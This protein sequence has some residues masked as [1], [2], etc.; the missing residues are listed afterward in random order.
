MELEFGNYNYYKVIDELHE[1]KDKSDLCYIRRYRKPSIWYY[2]IPCAFDI[3]TTSYKFDN[4]RKGAWMYE[5]TF[6]IGDDLIIYGRNWVDWQVLTDLL[7]EIF[8][9]GEFKRLFIGIHNLSFEFQ[10]M[11]RYFKW[12]NVFSNGT[13]HPIYAVTNSGLEFRCTAT[14]SALPLDKVAE[15]LTEHT[16]K[17]LKGD[18]DYSVI[19][20]EYT[21]LT[22]EEL[23]YCFNDVKILIYYL[24]EQIKQFGDIAHI[25]Y[26]NTGRVRNY[27]K[28]N[29][30]FTKRKG[31]KTKCSN[32]NYINLMKSLTLS[33]SEYRQCKLAFRGGFTHT[34]PYY[35]GITLDNVTSYDLTSAYPSVMLYEKFPMSSPRHPEFNT[36]NIDDYLSKYACLFRVTFH[37]LRKRDCVYDSYLSWIPN[38]M[39]GEN[40]DYS[41]NGRVVNAEMLSVYVTDV[42]YK[43]IKRAYTWSK[44]EFANL[45][46]WDYGYLPT[47]FIKC[48]LELYKNKTTLKGVSDKIIEYANSKGMLNSSYG[49]MVQDPLKDMECY[50]DDNWFT[51]GVNTHDAL[52]AYNSKHSRFNYYAWGLWITAYTRALIW[53]VILHIGIDYV[54]SDTDSVKLLNGDNYILYFGSLNDEIKRKVAQAMEYH[55]LPFTLASPST[56]KGEIKLIGVFDNEGVYDKFKSLGAKRYLT[57]KDGKYEI[58]VAGCGKKAI[59]YIMTL[60]NPFEVFNDNLFIPGKYTGKLTHSYIDDELNDWYIINGNIYH[61][62][63]KSSVHLEPCDYDL[64]ING[65]FEAFVKGLIEVREY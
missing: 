24:D 2:N 29:C 43:V 40:V 10:F 61:V 33:E 34:N 19:R 42:D 46:I 44:C 59:D 8:E 23:Q 4:K 57:Y 60:G 35:V 28:S 50:E 9:L 5:W 31:T 21:P 37:N 52:E 63:S 22:Q 36:D 64:S 20:D 1:I 27:Y 32:L 55:N 54:Y 56:I 25:P 3:E 39:K 51:Q 11:R 49:C 41:N 13:R 53:E 14:L 17:K 58:T 30:L 45:T 15:N 26:T 6:G 62:D 18:L 16:I 48:M 65:E 7:V 47:D 38:K 12:L